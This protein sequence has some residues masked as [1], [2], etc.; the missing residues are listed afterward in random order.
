MRGMTRTVT[1]C[2]IVAA[3]ALAGVPAGASALMRPDFMAVVAAVPVAVEVR[4]T[5]EGP[6]TP[7]SF[8]HV[9]GGGLM[10]RRVAITSARGGSIEAVSM[11]G[12]LFFAVLDPDDCVGSTVPPGGSC[13]VTVVV[14]VP[15]DVEGSIEDR[16]NVRIAGA[17]LE[18]RVVALA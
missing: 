12:G 2:C 16:L 8:G 17:T 13:T 10:R 6:E 15:R 7:E 14:A 11:T 9:P 18:G 1:C 3:I 4:G 5:G